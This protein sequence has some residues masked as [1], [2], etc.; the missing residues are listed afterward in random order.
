VPSEARAVVAK[1]VANDALVMSR[2]LMWARRVCIVCLP[3]IESLVSRVSRLSGLCTEAVRK[4]RALS[5][6]L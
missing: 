6:A 4:S 1:P 2:D 5:I 3:G